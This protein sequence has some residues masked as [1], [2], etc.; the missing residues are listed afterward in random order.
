[1]IVQTERT[2]CTGCTAC[3]AACPVNC[4][5]MEND[6]EGFVYPKVDKAVCIGCG[7]CERVCPVG[8]TKKAQG[9]RPRAWAVKAEDMKL[10]LASSSGGV[11]SLLAR[12]VLKENGAVFGAAMTG[13]CTGAAH[14]MTEDEAGLARLRGSKYMQSSV[15]D[16]FRQAKREL[17][18]GRQVLYT[19][20]PCQID[21]LNAFLGRAYENL[22]TVEVICHGAPSPELWRKYVL[23]L[24]E[25]SG[26]PIRKA[27]FR[28]KKCGWKLFGTRLENSNRRVLYSTLR[29]DPYIQMFLRNYCLRPSCYQCSSKGLDRSADLTI[30]DFWGIEGVAPE[31]DDDKG[32]SVVLVHSSK[33]AAALEAILKGAD[34]KAVDLDSALKGNPV[35]LHSV[36]RPP[37]RDA[38]FED[39]ARLT[40]PELEKK[41]VPKS[42]KD[43]LKKV[44]GKMGLLPM[45]YRLYGGMR[46]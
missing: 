15:G 43:V 42:G 20:T 21:G 4:I 41:Y 38:F 29:E 5:A 22:L 3:L 28:H 33:G 39:M 30:G 12:N 26:A 46:R 14:I 6:G 24:G 9:I 16:T 35:M 13:D 36:S 31:L 40:F 45:L 27:E 2:A 17:D 19:G 11:F 18:G 37:Q 32:A 25:R 8:R 23:Y 7:K 34:S 44:L 10:R 1:M